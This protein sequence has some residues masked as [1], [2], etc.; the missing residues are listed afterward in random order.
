MPRL[1]TSWCWR[2]QGPS[3]LA[4]S[5]SSIF[6]GWVVAYT[7]ALPP[8]LCTVGW[9]GH[10]FRGRYATFL[11]SSMHSRAQQ[12]RFV[13]YT[14][15]TSSSDCAPYTLDLLD[16]SAVFHQGNMIPSTDNGCFQT[17]PGQAGWNFR[18]SSGSTM[19]ASCSQ[20][21]TSNA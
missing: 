4:T 12:L 21:R 13:R 10:I 7:V 18:G 5:F 6:S 17:E 1:Q 3:L 2:S 9:W 16:G 20:A 11:M 8:Y 15:A 14:G 19:T